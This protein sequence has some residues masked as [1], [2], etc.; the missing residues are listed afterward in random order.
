METF[1]V[2]ECV[3]WCGWR[4]PGLVTRAGRFFLT[5]EAD[6]DNLLLSELRSIL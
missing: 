3:Q 2:G 1:T 6:T 4:F 5:L